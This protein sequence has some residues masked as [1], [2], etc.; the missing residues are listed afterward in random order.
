MSLT[1]TLGDAPSG[2][3]HNE[4]KDYI[5]QHFSFEALTAPLVPCIYHTSGCKKTFDIQ[6]ELEE[7]V[8]RNL[9]T[10]KDHEWCEECNVGFTNIKAI[11]HH[12]VVSQ[13]HEH[14]CPVC[15][16]EFK[17][18]GGLLKHIKQDYAKRKELTCLA[19]H[20]VF[21]GANGAAIQDLLKHI[22]VAGAC[23]AK[24][25]SD[26][27]NQAVNVMNLT[28]ESGKAQWP[29]LPTPRTETPASNE[30]L[31][32]KHNSQR[33]NTLRIVDKA[34]KPKRVTQTAQSVSHESGDKVEPKINV[35]VPATNSQSAF[36]RPND[37]E[38]E[39]KSE[40]K[41]DETT[42]EQPTAVMPNIASVPVAAPTNTIN[43]PSSGL[44]PTAPRPFSYAGAVKVSPHN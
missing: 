8:L 9:T 32:N 3:S 43:L 12:Y 38:Q 21:Y 6:E 33:V 29:V 34:I 20:E 2:L 42:E 16:K 28:D 22:M 30:D 13:K 41:T 36:S 4:L 19:C 17:S 26:D 37:W 15:A 14:V 5:K 23:K 31:T 35:D 10:D 27:G 24:Q 18:S 25:N 44:Q 40:H 11:R 1:S 39:R 7:H